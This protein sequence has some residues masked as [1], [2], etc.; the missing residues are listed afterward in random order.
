VTAVNPEACRQAV[1]EAALVLL[2]RMGLTPADLATVPLSR[3]EVPARPPRPPPLPRL[4]SCPPAYG[5]HGHPGVQR[6]VRLHGRG[7][8]TGDDN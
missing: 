4:G 3:P 7:C 1:V 5:R 6:P 8:L 2:E